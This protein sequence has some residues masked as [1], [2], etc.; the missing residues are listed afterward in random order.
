MTVSMTS[1]TLL[2][3]ATQQILILGGGFAG[4]A[5]ARELRR[6]LST[7]EAEITMFS[8]ENHLV[9]SPL[10]ADA[11]GASLNPLDVVVPLRQ[12]LPGVNCRTQDI[13][14]VHLEKNRVE[15][16]G[17][18]SKPALFSYDHLVIA[19]GQVANLNAVPGMAEAP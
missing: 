8:Q 2:F 6:Q 10:L 17:E 1:D 18:G 4:V 19:C 13:V 9:F 5:C 7:A 11:V 3:M 14:E 12:L 15:G 16:A